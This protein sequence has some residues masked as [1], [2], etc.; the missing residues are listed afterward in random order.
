MEAGRL[1][2]APLSQSLATHF[3][4]KNGP[5]NGAK[6]GVLAARIAP[7][8]ITAVVAVFIAALETLAE[9]VVVVVLGHIITTIAIV[10]VLIGIRALVV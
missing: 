7:I 10:R 8:L 1:F 4:V 6:D 5:Q 3:H 9:V 2:C